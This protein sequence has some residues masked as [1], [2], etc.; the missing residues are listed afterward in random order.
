MKDIHTLGLFLVL[1]S[2]GFSLAL[3]VAYCTH[4]NVFG[5]FCGVSLL[6]MIIGLFLLLL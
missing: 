5:F 3:F 6:F 4:E 2:L 1:V